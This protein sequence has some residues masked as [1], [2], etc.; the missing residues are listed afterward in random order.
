MYGYPLPYQTELYCVYTPCNHNNA[1]LLILYTVYV[2]QHNNQSNYTLHTQYGT[3]TYHTQF[4]LIYT[5]VIH[6]ILH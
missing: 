6:T 2:L 3:Y 4:I 1:T 5:H